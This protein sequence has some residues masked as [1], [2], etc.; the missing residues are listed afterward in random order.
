MIE[1]RYYEAGAATSRRGRLW[2]RS[3][4]LHLQIEDQSQVLHPILAEL[5]DKLGKVPCK[6]TFA[7]GSVFEA[8]AG[9][10][11]DELMGSH[12]SF[13]SVLSRL[14]ASWR[15]VAFAAIATIILFFGIY[16][17]GLPLAAAGAAAVT[18][19]IAVEAI[20]R[21]TMETIER[22]FFSESQLE[23]T[24]R[25]EIQLIFNEL[26]EFA[27]MEAAQLELLFRD[28]GQLDANAFALP[29]GTI[30]IT[31]QLVDLAESD[32][33]I[34]GVLAHEIAH[35]QNRHSLQQIYR[36]LGIGIMIGIIGGDSSQIIDDVVTHAAALQQL[37]YT[38]EFEEDA[39]RRSVEIIVAAGRDP[40]AFLDLLDRIAGETATER[41]T[42]WLSSHP[43]NKDRRKAVTDLAR[44]LGWN[45]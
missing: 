17:Y 29:G 21:G 10:D 15:F 19:Q 16:R 14:E 41:D 30:V 32:D 20:D 13:F 22:A 7:D 34:A 18:P 26:A 23:Q 45:G 1:G 12:S 43:G 5:S 11:V 31:D 25:A 27:A 6:L 37:T 4:E 40:T 8:P 35:V 2:G 24:R 33:E 36:V 38:R 39:D 44:R 42:S 3:G 28:G 9:A